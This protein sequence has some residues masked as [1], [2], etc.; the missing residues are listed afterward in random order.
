MVCPLDYIDNYIIHDMDLDLETWIP[1][2]KLRNPTFNLVKWYTRQLEEK[3]TFNS[4]YLAYHIPKGNNENVEV[5]ALRWDDSPCTV[6]AELEYL[7]DYSEGLRPGVMGGVYAARMLAVLHSCQPY[8]GDT[9]HCL[10]AP[11]PDGRR[12]EIDWPINGLYTIYD[13]KRGFEAYIDVTR[14]RYAQFSIGEW[15]AAEC[16]HQAEQAFPAEVAAQWAQRNL[17]FILEDRA[18]KRT[19]SSS[20]VG[21]G[22]EFPCR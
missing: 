10:N 5:N 2:Q 13:K 3:Q 8:P 11:S 18:R 7:K 1:I 4:L 16:A 17:H 12:F 15:Y 6:S 22:R 20:I 19:S 14:L 21:G 9:D